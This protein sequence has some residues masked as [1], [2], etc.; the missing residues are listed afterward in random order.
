MKMTATELR[1]DLFQ[2]LD[3]AMSGEPVIVTYKGVVFQLATKDT[4]SKM[5]RLVRRHSLLVDPDSII[6][7]DKEL[8]AELEAKWAEEDKLL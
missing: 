6:G 4:R 2:S 7:S 8:M 3:R 5:S 1:K